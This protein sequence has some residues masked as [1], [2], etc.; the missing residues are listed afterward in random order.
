FRLAPCLDLF[1]GP[2]HLRFRVPALRHLPSPFLRPKSYLDLFGKRGAGHHDTYLDYEAILHKKAQTIPIRIAVLPPKLQRQMLEMQFG[3]RSWGNL[4]NE[5]N[6]KIFIK[7][8]GLDASRIPDL[9]GFVDVL[10]HEHSQKETA[11]S[12]DMQVREYNGDMP[13]YLWLIDD[14]IAV[15]S[16]PNL[17]RNN[18]EETAF[19]TEDS[20]L[21]KQL[22]YVFESYW[23]SAQP[24]HQPH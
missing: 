20:R 5:E 3:A 24:I 2:D 15:L 4:S 1:Q 21:I 11:F 17:A 7:S 18:P 8:E 10:A 13:V 16:I 22:S 12:R 14:K 19:R 23:S 9:A 6:Y